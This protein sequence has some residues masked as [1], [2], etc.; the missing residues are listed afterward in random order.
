MQANAQRFE[1]KIMARVLEVSTS[2]YYAWSKRGQS[3]R[4]SD[5]LALLETIKG[6]YDASRGSYGSPRVHAALRRAGSGVSKHRVARL[7]RSSGLQGKSYRQRRVRTTHSV[8]DQPRAINRLE[9]DFSAEQPN[10]KWL[11]DITYLDT[12]QG[13]LYLCVVL[14]VYSRRIIGWAF[15]SGLEAT[16]VVRAFEMACQARRPTES[17]LFHSDQGVQYASLEFRQ[18]LLRLK[19]VQSMSRKGD[20]WDNAPCESLFS[21][22]KLELNLRKLHGTKLE[23]E[24]LVFE[25]ME[26]FYNRQRLHSSLG[27]QSPAEFE[28]SRAS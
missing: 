6:V 4:A 3:K 24:A 25:W 10:Q 22:L 1:M 28:F 27:Y 13:W 12:A 26:V 23:T 11:S 17:V 2:G 16:L 15:S 7:M 8:H 9:R 21:T 18:A 5:N 19:V 14:D 20:C